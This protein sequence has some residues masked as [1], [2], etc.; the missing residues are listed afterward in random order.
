VREEGGKSFP[1]TEKKPNE[2]RKEGLPGRK[3]E[4]MDITL[5]PI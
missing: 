5:L 2:E 3:S 4:K 1:C